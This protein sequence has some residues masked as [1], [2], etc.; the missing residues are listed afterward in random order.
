MILEPLSK[1][2]CF[3]P[4]SHWKGQSQEQIWV[5]SITEVSYKSFVRSLKCHWKTASSKSMSPKKYYLDKSICRKLVFISSFW[6]C[7]TKQL[8]LHAEMPELPHVLAASNGSTL[9]TDN[10]V[11]IT[12][13]LHVRFGHTMKHLGAKKQVPYQTSCSKSYCLGL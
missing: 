11:S 9:C 8:C 5:H 1:S 12:F 6:R 3:A 13:E 2:Y 7:P 10:W 4:F